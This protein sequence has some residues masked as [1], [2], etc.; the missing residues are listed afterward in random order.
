MWCYWH[1]I[2]KQLQSIRAE[3]QLLRTEIRGVRFLVN[4]P[5][6]ISLTCTG[7]NDMAIKFAVVLPQPPDVASDWAEITSGELIVSI[8]MGEPIVIAT[9][10]AVQETELRRVVDER[11]VGPQNTLVALAFAYIDDAGNKGA[12]VTAVQELL[13]TVPP[14]APTSIG[15][16]ETEETPDV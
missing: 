14:V 13:D 8:G 10:K 15:L 9:D 11:F 5:S 3:L 6:D 1:S 2:V 12:S 4:R 7:E 16:V